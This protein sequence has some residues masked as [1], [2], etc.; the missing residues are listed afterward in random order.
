MEEKLAPTGEAPFNARDCVTMG[1]VPLWVK[2]SY[3][4]P[5]FTGKETRH[6]THLLFSRQEHAEHRQV[7]YR[8]ALRLE[9]MEAVQR[10]SQWSL[11][12]QPKIQS[13]TLHWIKICRGDQETNQ[14]SL[15]KVRLLERE[16][17]LERLIIDGH[18][19]LLLVLEDVRPGDVIDSCYTIETQAR[20]LPGHYAS[21]FAL[22][23]G[24]AIG[25]YFFSL[26]FAAARSMK[27]KSSGSELTPVQTGEEGDNMWVWSGGSHEGKPVEINTPSW[28]LAYPWVQVSDCPDWGTVAAA[29]AEAWPENTE[30]VAVTEMLAEITGG[31]TDLT[32]QVEKTIQFVQ[33]GFRYLSVNLEFGG[34]IPQPPGVVIRKRYGDCKDL[35]FLLVHLLRRLGVAARPV[36]VHAQLRK[37]VGD[38][39]PMQGFNHVVVEFTLQGETRWVDAVAKNQGGG[40]LNRY[41]SK[42]GVGLPVDRQPG[43]GLIPAPLVSA[44]AHL[45]ELKETILLDTTGAASQLAVLLRTT[46][47]YAD[48]L[49]RQFAAQGTAEVARVRQ[50][51]CANRYSQAKRVGTLEY[52]DDRA[53]NEF[54]L[55]EVFEISGFLKTDPRPGMYRF[56]FPANLVAGTLAMPGKEARRTPFALPYPCNLVHV[57]DI[58]TPGQKLNRLD[59]LPIGNEFATFNRVLDMRRGWLSLTLNFTTHGESVPPKRVDEYR[60]KLEDIFKTS[61]WHYICAAGSSHPLKRSSFGLLPPPPR[62]PAPAV[63]GSPAQGLP[64]VNGSP[65][66]ASEPVK[67][68]SSAGQSSGRSRRH[69]RSFVKPETKLLRSLLAGAM[70]FVVLVIILLLFRHRG[71]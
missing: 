29:V 13:I 10:N 51:A 35:A 24:V 42:Y 53:A 66:A 31:S 2:P 26:R 54:L 58:H 67:T 19:T 65:L 21:F 3:Y 43:T 7:Y 17:G 59:R 32:A 11:Q 71:P 37:S 20:L 68:A 28:Y 5:A 1:P 50:T 63:P 18:F 57:L 70:A 4:D 8:T 60:A 27:W 9:S 64:I 55:A 52:R 12:L 33:D 49:R 14:A 69:S 46:G 44:K 38:L 25:A 6:F 30:D 61:S 56:V 15:G 48:A 39:L 41:V 23:Q 62:P 34:Q 16:E 40:P 45:Y 36:L 47:F 22:P